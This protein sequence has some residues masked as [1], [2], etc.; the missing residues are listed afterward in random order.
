M[1][2]SLLLKHKLQFAKIIRLKCNV[3]NS[4]CH[5]CARGAVVDINIE[6]RWSEYEILGVAFWGFLKTGWR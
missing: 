5:V 4:K 2:Y 3:S 1:N 6:S